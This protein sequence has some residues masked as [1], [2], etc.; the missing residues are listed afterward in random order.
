MKHATL[1]LIL[2]TLVLLPS[3][4]AAEQI[5]TVTASE[6]FELAGTQLPASAARAPRCAADG[7][8]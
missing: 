7:Q 5:G 1:P 2:F 8:G 6:A 4:F 3:A